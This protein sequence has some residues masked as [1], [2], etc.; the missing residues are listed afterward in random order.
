MKFTDRVYE[1]VRD[2][3]ALMWGG[4]SFAI[5]IKLF[6]AYVK[7]L[8]KF[9]V[10]N[11]VFK[12]IY[13]EKILGYT[14]Y[15]PEYELF[16]NLFREIFIMKTYYFKTEE[17]QPLI[18]D[19]GSSIGISIL[20]FKW[21]YPSAKIIGFEPLPT[22]YEYLQRNVIVNRL[23][24]VFVYN[25]AV[26]NY[27]GL[28]EFYSDEELY[29]LSSRIVFSD[30]KNLEYK[31]VQVKC[32]RLSDYIT[33]NVELLKL[34]IEGSELKVLEEIKEKLYLIRRI[35]LEFHPFEGQTIKQ[36][37]ENSLIR[38]LNILENANY[39]YRIGSSIRHELLWNVSTSYNLFIFAYK[40]SN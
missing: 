39:H 20:F 10:I 40:D 34:D 29:S 9:F 3:I 36:N 32:C 21:L 24:N 30:F 35:I 6:F 13:R 27:E 16:F 17:K 15:F 37:K 26:Y 33:E 28:V 1:I 25:F 31:K 18:I 23:S 12:K 11:N 8:F 4:Y 2:I 14:I 22:S 19:C 5:K 7:I 38:L